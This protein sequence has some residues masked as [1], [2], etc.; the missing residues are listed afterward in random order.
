MYDWKTMYLRDVGNKIELK[1]KSSRLCSQVVKVSVSVCFQ[2]VSTH[3]Y[4]KMFGD[5]YL[6]FI[7]SIPQQGNE[8]P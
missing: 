5:S 8:N 2:V 6:D 7:H 3:Q 1:E 4:G